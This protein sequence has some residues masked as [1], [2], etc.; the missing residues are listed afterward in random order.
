MVK[1]HKIDKNALNQLL[2]KTGLESIPENLFLDEFS[3]WDDVSFM[4]HP[5]LIM[6]HIYCK[7]YWKWIKNLA[8]KIKSNKIVEVGAGNGLVSLALRHLGCDI[9]AVDNKKWMISSTEVITAD[10]VSYVQE[11][12]FD[13]LLC[14]WPEMSDMFYLTCENF[15]K[16][17]KNGKIIYCGENV[18]GC[19]ASDKF[20]DNYDLDFLDIGYEPCIGLY[21]F[22]YVACKKERDKISP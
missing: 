5:K 7:P 8:D 4:A 10:A 21:D 15:L 12:K 13:V 1:R 20:F 9:T 2:T 3:E 22:F 17:N 14:C 18:G 16:N 11:N 19:T 6:K